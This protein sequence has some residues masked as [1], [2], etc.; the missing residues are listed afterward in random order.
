MDESTV[1]VRDE[2]GGPEGGKNV[3]GPS[4]SDD[5]LTGSFHPLARAVRVY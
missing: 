3:T 5:G 1:T 4:G 2:R